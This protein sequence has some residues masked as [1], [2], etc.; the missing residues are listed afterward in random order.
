[1]KGHSSDIRRKLITFSL[2]LSYTNIIVRSIKKGKVVA[3]AY[4]FTAYIASVTWINSLIEIFFFSQKHYIPL[5]IQSLILLNTSG[6]ISPCIFTFCEEKPTKWNWIFNLPYFQLLRGSCPWRFSS[7]TQSFDNSW[8]NSRFEIQRP[9]YTYC[10]WREQ[11]M[12][13]ASVTF[14]I[15]SISAN[16]TLEQSR[17]SGVICSALFRHLCSE[18]QSLFEWTLDSLQSECDCENTFTFIPAIYKQSWSALFKEKLLFRRQ[19][20][21]KQKGNS[22]Y[23]ESLWCSTMKW[24]GHVGFCCRISTCQCDPWSF[25]AINAWECHCWLTIVYCVLCTV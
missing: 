4:N 17:V 20:A 25:G 2:F 1:M 7:A 19:R 12:C 9:K 14:K 6:A 16:K 5:R 3:H 13:A 18:S 11:M 8:S 21:P 10:I 15:C 23:V 22:R 24:T